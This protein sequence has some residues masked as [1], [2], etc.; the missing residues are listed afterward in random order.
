M[1]ERTRV[2]FVCVGNACRS[3]MAEAFLR[4]YNL[5]WLTTESAGLF[6]LGFLPEKTVLV[7]QE[8]HVSLDGQRSKGLESI[9]W[10]GVTVLVNMT[11]YSVSSFLPHFTGQQ[12][13]WDVP[14]PFE[15]SM[16]TYRSV[17][18]LVEKKVAELVR[19][20]QRSREGGSTPASLA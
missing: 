8:K 11:S 19:S 4:Q 12:E 9:D 18:D 2:V 15:E 10:D 7:M 13:C 6:P 14:D 17:R 16:E 3:Q 5:D 1:I 20:F